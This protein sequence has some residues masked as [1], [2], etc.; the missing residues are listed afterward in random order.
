MDNFVGNRIKDL[1]KLKGLS[2][3]QLAQELGISLSYMSQLESGKSS[4]NVSTLLDIAR[5]LNL[6]SIAMLLDENPMED[7]SMVRTGDRKSYAR[8]EG[9]V[10]IDI[11]FATYNRQLEASIVHLP[12]QS[13]TNKARSHR[14]DEFCYV[15]RGYVKLFLEGKN[16]YELGPGDVVAYP[17]EFPHSWKNIGDVEAEVL[18][19]CTPVSF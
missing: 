4:I 1:R 2:Q 18:V 15:I 5:T 19:A 6:P 13:D 12:V 14:G 9:N 7:V 3:K 11:L 8:N 16:E 17:A 10:T